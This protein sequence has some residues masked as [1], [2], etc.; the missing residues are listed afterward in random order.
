MF[1]RRS[2]SLLQH[3]CLNIQVH[4]FSRVFVCVRGCPS[5]SL[6][7]L[8]PILPC[9]LPSLLPSVRLSVRYCAFCTRISIS[10]VYPPQH[11]HPHT[12]P[13][14]HTHT[15]PSNDVTAHSITILLITEPVIKFQPVKFRR[16]KN[17][18]VFGQ[19]KT[20]SA[21]QRTAQQTGSHPT[22]IVAVADKICPFRGES[23]PGGGH[24]ELT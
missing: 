19:F 7:F 17:A 22:A 18:S 10:L 15:H 4:K 23:S 1:A 3:K 14:T 21:R 12:H 8:S 11:P 6:S 16:R 24:P 2:L 9:I 13:R 20:A 5:N